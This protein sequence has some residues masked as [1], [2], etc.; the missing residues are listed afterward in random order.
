MQ[1]DSSHKFFHL[2][3]ISIVSTKTCTVTRPIRTAR[4]WVCRL[5]PFYAVKN[6]QMKPQCFFFIIATE[7][8]SFNGFNLAI[9]TE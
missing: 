2:I 7:V 4:R 8:W 9:T 5:T 6:F 1:F 3:C